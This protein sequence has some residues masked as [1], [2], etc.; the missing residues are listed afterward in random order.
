MRRIGRSC[1]REKQSASHSRA[2]CGSEAWLL[3]VRRLHGMPSKQKH[4]RAEQT[5]Y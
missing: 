1:R 3:E 4:A 2:R 5:W